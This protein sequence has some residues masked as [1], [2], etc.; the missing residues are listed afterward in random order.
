MSTE[1][2]L[3]ISVNSIHC[4]KMGKERGINSFKYQ[5]FAPMGR[6]QLELQIEGKESENSY[7][8]LKRS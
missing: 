7:Q 1:I 6:F 4:K 2:H 5:V 8:E 3:I